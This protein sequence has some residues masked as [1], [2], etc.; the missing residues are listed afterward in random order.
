MNFVDGDDHV[1][2]YEASWTPGS[3][4]DLSQVRTWVLRFFGICVLPPVS[5]A[6]VVH[7][8]DIVHGQL[9]PKL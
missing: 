2:I 6:Q 1:H 5:V 4:F 3:N 8:H 9:H 7:Q